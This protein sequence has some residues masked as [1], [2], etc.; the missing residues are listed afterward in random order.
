MHLA[1]L[2]KEKKFSEA[3]TENACF[4]G[5]DLGKGDRLDRE[6]SCKS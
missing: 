1:C 6:E 5:N 2:R 3:R 4:A